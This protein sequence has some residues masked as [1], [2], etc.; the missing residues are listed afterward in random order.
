MQTPFPSLFWIRYA[1]FP[2]QLGGYYSVLIVFQPTIPSQTC[3]VLNPAGTIAG[4]VTDGLKTFPTAFAD[5]SLYNISIS[6]FT[7]NVLCSIPGGDNCLRGANV[8]SGIDVVC[9]PA[10]APVNYPVRV[11][12]NGL[13]N[14]ITAGSVPGSGILL[15]GL[16]ISLNG[17]ENMNI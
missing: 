5:G 14:G 2:M 10:A 13:H 9:A 12:V 15:N 1:L 7:V 6:A 3:I 16:R 11:Q 4:I 8:T 17:T